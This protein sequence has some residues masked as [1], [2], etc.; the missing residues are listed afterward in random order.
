MRTGR[1]RAGRREP[2]RA[3]LFP[4][5]ENP[6]N[7]TASPPDAVIRDIPLSRLFLAPENVRKTPTYGNA[8][9]EL[10]ASIEAHGLLENLVARAD[11][12]DDDGNERF[13]VLAGGR[14]LAALQSLAGDGALDPELPVPCRIV[15]DA[16]G[17]ELSLAEN[18]VRIAM[19]PADQVAAFSALAGDGLS[20]AAIA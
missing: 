4:P 10:K 17:G 7:P 9:A 3:P 18:V 19:H 5:T 11:G 15:P 2:G 6:M 16:N 13:A 14:R 8:L 12:T 1:A 20:V